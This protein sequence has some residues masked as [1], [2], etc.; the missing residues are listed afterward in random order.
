M[1][2]NIL[3]IPQTRIS[4][5]LLS[6]LFTA[7]A[8]LVDFDAFCMETVCAVFDRFTKH[9]PYLTQMTLH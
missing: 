5:N 8:G 4:R 6:H 7:C 2:F 9:K 3:N 1:L